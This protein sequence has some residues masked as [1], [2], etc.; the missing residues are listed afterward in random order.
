MASPISAVS[1]LRFGWKTFRSR[2]WLFVGSIIIYAAV[3]FVLLGIEK[4]LGSSGEILMV[5]I[6]L[7]VGTVLAVG[8]MSLYLKAHDDLKGASFKD[9]WNLAPFWQYLVTS[10]VIAIIV[11]LGIF[12]LI[13]PGIIF[14]LAFSM[15]PY[16]V[17]EKKMWTQK[18]L[19]ESWRLTKG[20]WLELFL[21][22]VAMAIINFLG[23]FL[24][25]VGL[26]VT[27]PVS[28]LAMTHVYRTLSHH[29]AHHTAHAS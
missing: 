21:L 5:F 22:G 19:K 7:G 29:K 26:L 23:A 2:P 18:A 6:N 11:I 27:A 25:L 20:H 8:L 10:V 4:F 14:A 9:M 16:L 13:V 12:A 3:Q 17:I 15:A 28:M 1:S 24:L